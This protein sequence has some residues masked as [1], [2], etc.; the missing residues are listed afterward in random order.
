MIKIWFI[1]RILGYNIY[2]GLIYIA[3]YVPVM[4]IAMQYL[5]MSSPVYQVYSDRSVFVIF[6]CSIVLNWKGRKVK[7]KVDLISQLIILKWIVCVLYLVCGK[8]VEHLPICESF[9]QQLYIDAFMPV[10]CKAQD[11]LSY[12]FHLKL[13]FLIPQKFQSCFFY[14]YVIKINI[15]TRICRCI[16]LDGNRTLLCSLCWFSRG[17]EQSDWLEI[18]LLWDLSFCH[19]FSQHGL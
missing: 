17:K 3:I 9:W 16:K 14:Y 12:F 6:I 10:F 2:I 1:Y 11:T 15:W 18:P 13:I 7:W 4:L 19:Q 8:T 5:L